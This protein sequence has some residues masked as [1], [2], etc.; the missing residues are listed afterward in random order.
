V[1]VKVIP[2]GEMAYHGEVDHAVKA[3]PRFSR[4]LIDVEVLEGLPSVEELHDELIGYTDVI[5]GRADPPQDMDSVLDLMEIA[6]AY[7]ARAKEIEMLIHW[8]E[9]NR[10]VIRGSPYYKL[11]TGQLRSF[12]EMAKM[13]AELGS[14]RLTQERLLFEARL[15]SGNGD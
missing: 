3:P 12:I 1:S 6:G 15:D 5:L 13:M 7:Y 2:V 14:R 9:Q 10:R 11:R 8:E 4:R